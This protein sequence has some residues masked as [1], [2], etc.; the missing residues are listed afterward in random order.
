MSQRMDKWVVLALLGGW[1]VAAG[2]QGG[3]DVA[4]TGSIEVTEFRPKT[5]DGWELELKRYRAKDAVKKEQSD[6]LPVKG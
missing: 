4:S 5:T 6:R 1:L 3:P 2:C